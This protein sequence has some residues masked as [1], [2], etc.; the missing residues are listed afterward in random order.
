MKENL[1]IV[2]PIIVRKNKFQNIPAFYVKNDSKN[3]NKNRML[4]LI[5]SESY[6]SFAKLWK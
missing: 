3:I 5:F 4:T 1:Y 6:L 2:T